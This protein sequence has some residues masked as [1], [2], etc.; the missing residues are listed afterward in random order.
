MPLPYKLNRTVHFCGA[1]IFSS[2]LESSPLPELI[3]FPLQ[4]IKGITRRACIGLKMCS[5]NWTVTIAT[6]APPVLYR[7]GSNGLEFL[8]EFTCW[9]KAELKLST[10]NQPHFSNRII[11]TS[12]IWHLKRW[13]NWSACFNDHEFNPPIELVGRGDLVSHQQ[14]FVHLLCYG[15]H[16][17]C[18][19]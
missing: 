6:K 4:T 15:C 13:M 14:R 16:S 12:V 7:C 9:E 17:L 2:G 3:L 10:E 8:Q 11:A 1:R 5:F 19:W 18:C